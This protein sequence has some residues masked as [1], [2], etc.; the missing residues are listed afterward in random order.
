MPAR[1]SELPAVQDALRNDKHI[2]ITAIANHVVLESPKLVW[3]HFEATENGTDLAKSVATALKTI[4][5]PQLNVI[6]IPGTNT[7]FDPSQ[8]LPPKFLKLF[9]EGF[10]EQ[11]NDIVAFYLPRP[12]ENRLTVGPVRA[13]AGL[14]IGQSFYIEIPIEGGSNNATLY[15]D[16]A[17]RAD[18][19]QPVSDVLRAGGFTISA[20]HNQFVNDSPHLYLVHASASSDDGFALGNTL[21]DAIQII[22]EKSR[23][24]RNHDWDND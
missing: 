24:A 20:Q 16:F 22:Q 14:G 9:D 11:F 10:V 1:E 23:Q 8:I 21:F 3:V 19:I 5:N 6:V 2:H 12:D 17:L 15:I 13:K 7:V 4:N 18:E